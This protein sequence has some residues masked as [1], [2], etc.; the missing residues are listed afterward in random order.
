[1]KRTYF[2]PLAIAL[3]IATM[4]SST[5]V[6]AEPINASSAKTKSIKGYYP[7]LDSVGTTIITGEPGDIQVGDV[8][9]IPT[10]DK[11]SQFFNLLD[12][13]TDPQLIAGEYSVVWW[14]AKPKE[15]Y[16]WADESGEGIAVTSWDHIDATKIN[17]ANYISVPSISTSKALQIPG[18]I[19][20]SR[21]AFSITPE[22]EFGDPVQGQAL[23]A[24]DINFFWSNTNPDQKPGMPGPGE[25]NPDLPGGN[26][27][28]PENNGPNPDGGG[29]TIDG[30]K[31]Y[32]ALIY[33]DV[34]GNGVYTPDVDILLTEEPTVNTQ[35]VV[36]IRI[37]TDQEETGF[38]GLTPA[39]QESIVWDFYNG[40]NKIND[41][42]EGL[43]SFAFKTQVTN[44]DANDI[45]KATPPNFSQQGLS[46]QVNFTYNDEQ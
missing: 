37:Y 20:G 24:A 31:S 1:M 30:S 10:D 41:A 27:L 40:E 18:N 28:D 42:G 7:S 22:T 15:G 25:S 14:S 34:D 45:L 4:L 21:I 6:F 3:S 44:D 36:D 9:A 33:E 39:E 43:G 17:E 32:A 35:Y 23:Y 19:G 38:R 12:R 29:N 16:K 8:I 11:G 26:G 46:L 2:K 5:F 13:D